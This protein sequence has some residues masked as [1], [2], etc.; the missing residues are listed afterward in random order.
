MKETFPNLTWMVWVLGLKLKDRPLR[1][2][3]SRHDPIDSNK[4]IEIIYT[5]ILSVIL[6]NSILYLEVDSKYLGPQESWY[7]SMLEFAA[8][9]LLSVRL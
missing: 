2:A 6:G 1:L 5:A 7:H 4:Q 3:A 8:S 9:F